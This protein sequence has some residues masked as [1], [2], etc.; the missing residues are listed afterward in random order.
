MLLD[1]VG[2]G[3][4]LL[5]RRALVERP[6]RVF[7]SDRFVLPLPDKHRFPMAKYRRLRERL[8]KHPQIEIVTPPAATD[9]ELL[10]THCPLYLESLKLGTVDPKL[11]RRLGFPYSAELVERSRR[12]VGAT[13]AACQEA[14]GQG[15]SANLAGG[16][17]HAS[18]ATPEGFCVFN[19]SVV[20]LRSLGIERAMVVDCDVH[21]G[22]GTASLT[23]GD[24]RIYTFSMHGEKN[25]PFRKQT[26][27]WDI[28]LPDGSGDSDYL[29]ALEGFL[30][31][32][33][34]VDLVIYLSGA[35]P[36]EGDRLGR[37]AL[38]KE[39]LA[40]RDRMVLEH[41]RSRGIPVAVTMGG[42]YA[43]NVED[44]VDIHERTVL[45]ALEFLSC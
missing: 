19:D 24:E 20:A 32:A 14:L 3:P 2:S 22:N 33:P 37:L 17:H 1:S 41:F 28:G 30:K 26:S 36:F 42:G 29:S 34:R 38:T 35:D 25:F 15:V 27:D 18:F 31:G 13:L 44:I 6:L 5:V 7:S 4:G 10:T 43:E 23:Q 12:S 21:Q 16:T 11:I 39:G 8:E 45:T 9:A 40:T